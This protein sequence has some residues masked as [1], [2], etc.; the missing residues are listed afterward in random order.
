MRNAAAFWNHLNMTHWWIVISNPL[1]RLNRTPDDVYRRL[2]CR[3]YGL[4]YFTTHACAPHHRNCRNAVRAE[5]NGRRVNNSPAVSRAYI[6]LND[7]TC[8]NPISQCIPIES[9]LNNN[10]EH[11]FNG[12]PCYTCIRSR[13][14]IAFIIHLYVLIIALSRIINSRVSTQS[15][16][17]PSYE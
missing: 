7:A 11:H 5:K 1:N 3:L 14:I 2:P 10:C 12:F 9:R 8:S 13:I 16:F 4:L 17:Q 6:S 15:R